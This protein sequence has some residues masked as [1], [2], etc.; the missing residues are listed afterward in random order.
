[1]D[2]ENN[3][4]EDSFFKQQTAK[5]N[6]KLKDITKKSGKKAS[7]IFIKLIKTHPWVLILLIGAILIIFLL[8]A[9]LYVIDDKMFNEGSKAKSNAVAI[10]MDGTT[11]ITDSTKIT[12]SKTDDGTY[13]IN[14]TFTDDELDEVK[15][16]LEKSGIDISE[17]TDFEIGII[18]GFAENGLDVNDY[19]VKE[20]KCLPVFL[21]AEAS[22][23]YL[24]LRKN[25]D[26]FDANGNYMP[27]QLDELGE[28]EVPG[29]ILVQRTNTKENTSMNLE[30]KKLEEFNT[31]VNNNDISV[32]NYFTINEKGNLVIAKWDHTTVTVNGKYP[33]G[34]SEE[35]KVQ[36]RD[37]T[38][39][40]TTEIPYNQYVTKYTMPFDFLLQ[41]LVT[42]EDTDF[43]MEVADI[44]L[45]SKII[46]NIQEEET[47]TNTTEV[48]TYDVHSKEE[49]IIDYKIEPNLES[50]TNYL[51]EKTEDDEGNKCTTYNHKTEVVTITTTNTSHTYNFEILESDT[52]IAHYKKTY[53]KQE[54]KITNSPP[55]DIN[56]TGEYQLGEE[57]NTEDVNEIQKD[58]DVN[59]FKK[60]KEKE[61]KDKVP[62]PNVKVSTH[63]KGVFSDRTYKEISITPKDKFTDNLS[64]YEFNE[65]EIK[66]KD[67]NITYGYD[68][69]TSFTVTTKR[70][71]ELPFEVNFSYRLNNNYTY[72]LSNT[73]KDDV[74]KCNISKLLIRPYN[75]INLNNN[76]TTT[77]T[78]YPS[79][80]NP[81]TNT[82]IYAKDDN[83]NFEKFLVAYDN[84]E[85]AIEMIRDVD[86]WLFEMMEESTST[87][88]LVDLLKYLLYKY[89]GSDYGITDANLSELLKFLEPSNL[90]NVTGTNAF[91]QFI[92]YLHSWEGG[93]TIYKDAQGVDCYK[94]QS[95]GGGGSA[96]G[97]GIDISTHGNRLRQLGYD[98]SIGALIPVEI[99]DE[100]EKEQIQMLQERVKSITSGLNLTEYQIY[101]LMSR[102][103]NYGVTGGLKQATSQFKYPSS[104]TFVTAYNKYYTNIN[105][106]DYYMDYTKTDFSNQL[107][108]QY[109]MWLDY[110]SSGT[111]PSGWEYRRK[112]EWSLFQT[113]YYGYDLIHG[114]GHGM[115]EYYMP[116]GAATD[117]T[118]NINLYNGD[119]SVNTDSIN[120]LNNWLTTDLLNTKIHKRTSEM[121]GGPFAKWWD[122]TNNWF[123]SAGLKFQ[124]TWYVYGR[125]NQFLE[126]YGTSY[127]AWPGTRND[128][129]KWYSSS[130]NGGEKYF[131]CGNTPRQNSIVVWK[132]GNNAGHVA[133]VEA[134]DTVNNKVYISHAGGGKSWFGITSHGINEMKNLWG[135]QLLGYV[136]LDSP[137]K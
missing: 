124:C 59:E 86:S 33:E 49:K 44:V 99:V 68:M 135:Y 52:W 56:N 85:K 13:D 74:L 70:T 69:P 47:I 38:T 35:E 15:E 3:N 66:D 93:G 11:G 31:L 9:F 108:T 62:V 122:S 26:K 39:I 32:I 5:A 54:E 103:Y 1:M 45:G 121:Q 18:G 77:I 92:R 72:S 36:S 21:K 102:C 4:N 123:T 106:E 113:G 57:I 110:A 101:A 100:I 105:N 91:E 43:C 117:F 20:L 114:T 16:K 30:Y 109:M 67:G 46:I 51:I 82:H 53:Q 120:Q 90:M 94:V 7:K 50:K 130:T 64:N 131:E 76:I 97:Y 61:Y 127:K 58:N 126:L 75:K 84:N 87:I 89:D 83:G 10:S 40:T 6:D 73:N 63:T 81:T 98:T 80:P 60:N 65:K 8:L 2:E 28:K 78:K 119:G 118:N 116:G 137:K 136:Y 12:I 111:H 95:D 55:E 37:D 41:L 14:N 71:N 42:T 133:Y 134:V 34:L 24:D 27:R 112:S 79:D 129:G 107:F 115:D 132:D 25:S 104:E 48:R 88:N 128:A 29:I 17:F 22:T 19:K 125:A 23:Q 96:V